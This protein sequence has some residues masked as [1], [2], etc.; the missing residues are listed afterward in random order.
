MVFW[1]L[2]FIPSASLRQHQNSGQQSVINSD[3]FKI[4][5]KSNGIRNPHKDPFYI[6]NIRAMH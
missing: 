2:V 1:A 4:H 3:M 6:G 5:A